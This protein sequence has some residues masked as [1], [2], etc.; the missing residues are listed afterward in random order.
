[1]KKGE[2]YTFPNPTDPI[3]AMINAT[4]SSSDGPQLSVLL[5]G[6]EHLG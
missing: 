2:T 6:R 3:G 1:M 4:S 5:S